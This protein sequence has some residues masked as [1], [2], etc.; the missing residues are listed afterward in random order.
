VVVGAIKG[1]APTPG[2]AVLRR[3][4]SR[5]ARL[6]WSAAQLHA[7]FEGHDWRGARAGAVISHLRQ[8]QS[9]S[10]AAQETAQDRPEWCGACDR[11]TR[12]L[13]DPQ[14]HVPRRC[15]TCHPKSSRK[16][17]A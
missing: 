12:L 3:E 15:P 11:A 2:R 7:V 14:T 9:P 5:L 1:K 4:L 17:S 10:S 6:Q 13:E 16:D 8:L